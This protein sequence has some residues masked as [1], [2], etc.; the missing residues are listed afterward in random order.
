MHQVPSRPRIGSRRGKRRAISIAFGRC[1]WIRDQTALKTG[2]RTS[3]QSWPSPAKQSPHDERQEIASKCSRSRAAH[4]WPSPHERGYA[5]GGPRP[6]I[7][8]APNRGVT[9]HRTGSLSQILIEI[10]I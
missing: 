9:S 3:R 7:V 2:S 4:L 1:Y 5:E 8:R 6:V 10:K